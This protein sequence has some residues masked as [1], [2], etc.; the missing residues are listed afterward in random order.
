MTH[1]RA[2]IKGLGQLDQVYHVQ[3]ASVAGFSIGIITID[4]NYV[5]L[6]GNVANATTFAF[7]VVYEDIVLEIEDLFNGEEKL[8]DMVIEAAKKLEK[9]GVRAIVGACG[10]FNHFQEQVRDAVAV[11]VYLSSVLQ[12]PLIKMRLKLDQKIAVL[13][14]D[15]AGANADFFAKANASIEDCIVQ[16]IGS[17]ESFAPIRYNK[18]YLDNG[19][20]KADLIAVV[21]DLR[22][23]HPE[24]AAILLECSDLPPYAAALHRET[25]LPVFDFTTLINWVHSAVVRREFYGYM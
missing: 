19:R 10:Y 22:A 20:L 2:S 25:G 9:K 14:A 1:F 16:E 17:L 18:P 21:Q 7:P 3:D 13:V 8:L 6:P 5:K 4:F 15:G 24:I 12:I 11:P 23:K